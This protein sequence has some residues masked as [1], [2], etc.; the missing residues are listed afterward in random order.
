MSK[1]AAG[2]HHFVT[3]LPQID[4]YILLMFYAD[5]LTPGEISL[6]LDLPQHKVEKCLAVLRDE[7]AAAMH[8]AAHGNAVG[9][10]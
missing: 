4:R 7:A 3:V 9:V 10:A 8:A 2:L 6:V 5:D 1:D